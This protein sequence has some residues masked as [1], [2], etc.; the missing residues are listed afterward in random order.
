MKPVTTE[1]EK[2][3]NDERRAAGLPPPDDDRGIEA[4]IGAGVG[5]LAGATA[6][7]IAGPI[8]A[9]LGATIGSIVG[10]ATGAALHR[11][12]HERVM[13]DHELDDAIGVTKGPLGT[14][15]PITF[16]R[17]PTPA[18]FLRADHDL[19]D[20]LGEQI[21]AAIEEDAPEETARAMSVMQLQIREHLAR[22]ERE[23]LTDFAADAPTEAERIRREHAEIEKTL[24]EME[25]ATDL[26]TLRAEAV[27]A[28][29]TRLRAHATREETGLYAWA[30]RRE[31]AASRD[32]AG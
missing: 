24:T 4:D 23:L 19:L 29:L 25:I 6:G 26:H 13:H 30:A 16:V 32:P 28:L 18:S 21:V 2:R 31:R 17:P 12:E 22:E 11:Q 27:R 14:G 20:T 9:V 15:A 7:A 3:E 5:L 10:G 8:G 1:A